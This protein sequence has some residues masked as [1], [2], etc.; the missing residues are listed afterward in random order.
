MKRGEKVI[1]LGDKWCT[2]TGDEERPIL[3]DK[4]DRDKVSAE[5]D[6]IQGKLIHLLN[7]ETKKITI[8]ARSKR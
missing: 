2:L 5:V 7:T 3:S 1:T 6:W 4:S 8:C